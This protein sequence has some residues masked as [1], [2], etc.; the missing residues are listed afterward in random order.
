MK[1]ERGIIYM[2]FQLEFSPLTTW[3]HAGGSATL[4]TNTFFNETTFNGAPLAQAS[5]TAVLPGSGIVGIPGVGDTPEAWDSSAAWGAAPHMGVPGCYGVDRESSCLAF[6]SKSL[7][8][9]S[10]GRPDS[11]I[12]SR[13]ASK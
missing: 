3:L 1:F 11:S 2:T 10:S 5:P 7:A 4:G 12:F 8:F 6:P 9:W 13:A